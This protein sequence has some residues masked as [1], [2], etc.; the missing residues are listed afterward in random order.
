MQMKKTLLSIFIF[1]LLV[2]GIVAAEECMVYDTI[3]E[4]YLTD[5]DCDGWPDDVPKPDNW[6]E[7][8]AEAE[9]PPMPE[10]PDEEPVPVKIHDQ[11]PMP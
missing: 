6:D 9:M 8:V 5:S 3:D 2:I 10:I 7:F 1:F 11:A 4:V